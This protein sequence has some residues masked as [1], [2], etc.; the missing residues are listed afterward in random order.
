MVKVSALTLFQMESH[1]LIL[2]IVKVDF[3]IITISVLHTQAWDAI[4]LLLDIIAMVFNV[5]Q[6]LTAMISF[7][8]LKLRLVK[9]LIQITK[10]VL[11]NF[12][13]YTVLV[14]LVMT[15]INA[16]QEFVISITTLVLM[17]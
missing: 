1:V 14:I 5:S 12:K 13:V 15:I 7:V 17:E 2:K 4:T 10:T 11:I 8:V 9:V 16:Y 6:I 3:V